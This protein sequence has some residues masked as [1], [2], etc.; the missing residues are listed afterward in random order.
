MLA[1]E[2]KDEELEDALERYP[3]SFLLADGHLFI[4]LKKQLTSD[5][6]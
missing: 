4:P 6:L 1:L 5:I 2:D 3:E